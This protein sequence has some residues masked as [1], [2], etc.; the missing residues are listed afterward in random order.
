MDLDKIIT[1]KFLNIIYNYRFR[2]IYKKLLYETKINEKQ[3]NN[4]IAILYAID[5]VPPC[6]TSTRKNIKEKVD[7][8]VKSVKELDYYKNINFYKSGFEDGY[9]FVLELQKQEGM[10]KTNE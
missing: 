1:D 3:K 7:T 10:D 4:Y 8:Y 2:S 5:N 9:K 6:F